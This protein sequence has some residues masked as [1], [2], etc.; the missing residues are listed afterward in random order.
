MMK[1]RVWL[2]QIAC[3]A[4]FLNWSVCCFAGGSVGWDQVRA[5][6]MRDDPGLLA[7]IETHFDIRHSGGAVR[8]GRDASGNAT[9]PELGVGAR[10]P[11]YEFYA[12]PKDT[13]GDYTLY[14]T[15]EPTKPPRSE[16]VVWQVTIRQKLPND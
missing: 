15:L 1:S 6:I 16:K 10:I 4:F 8:V 12:K 3:A 7:F 11:P 13:P 5:E 2:L 9:I 14:L